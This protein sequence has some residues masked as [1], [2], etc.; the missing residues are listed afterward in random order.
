M[1]FSDGSKYD[2]EFHQDFPDGRGV[3]QNQI[4]R[5]EGDFKMGSFSGKGKLTLK[6]GDKFEGL[7]EQNEQKVGILIYNNED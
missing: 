4:M 6:N 5:Y 3:Y 1:K 7:F 2:G